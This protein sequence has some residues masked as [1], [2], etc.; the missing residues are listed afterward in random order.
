M[1]KDFDFRGTQKMFKLKISEWDIRKNLNWSERE[2]VCQKLAEKQVIMGKD[3]KVIVRGQER[4][5]ALFRRHSQRSQRSTERRHRNSHRGIL[6]RA[7]EFDRSLEGSLLMS[8][9]TTPQ[10]RR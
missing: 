7:A 2:V 3:A 6:M 8:Q 4:R 1:Q 9:T 10:T 5:L